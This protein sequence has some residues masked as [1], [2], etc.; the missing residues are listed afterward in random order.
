MTLGGYD[1][2]DSFDKDAHKL[3]AHPISGSFHWSVHIVRIGYGSDKWFYSTKTNALTDTGT[4][5]IY[6]PKG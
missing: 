6:F 4:T 1:D 3:I 2:T 5:L